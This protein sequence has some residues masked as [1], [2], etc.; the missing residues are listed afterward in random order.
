MSLPRYVIRPTFTFLQQMLFMEHIPISYL[1]GFTSVEAVTLA[2]GSVI[3]AY[4]AQGVVSYS[5]HNEHALF[6]ECFFFEGA[7]TGEQNAEA[8]GYARILRRDINI[9][10]VYMRRVCHHWIFGLP[11]LWGASERQHHAQ[12]H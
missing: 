12:S 2:A 9:R 11:H 3:Y 1:P 8:T 6:L 7:T 4:S 5:L 10:C